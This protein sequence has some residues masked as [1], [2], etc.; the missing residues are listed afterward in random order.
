MKDQKKWFQAAPE[1]FRKNCVMERVVKH[2]NRLLWEAQESP[3]LEVSKR[4][5]DVQTWSLGIEFHSG[6][7]SFWLNSIILRVFSYLNDFIL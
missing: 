6:L 4:Y 3:S 7:G 2:C 5:A 1:R